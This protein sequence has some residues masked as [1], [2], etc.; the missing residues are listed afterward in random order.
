MHDRRHGLGICNSQFVV[1]ALAV[2]AARRRHDFSSFFKL[3][4]EAPYLESCIMFKAA[5]GL[6]DNGFLSDESM[7]GQAIRAFHKALSQRGSKMP[8]SILTNILCCDDDVQTKELLEDHGIA[9][10]VENAKDDDSTNEK[11]SH[12]VAV[13]CIMILRE[14]SEVHFAA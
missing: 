3:L 9:C 4:K 2:V 7:R 1:F 5:V 13:F 11:T 10:E 12:T 6:K 8:L 14:E